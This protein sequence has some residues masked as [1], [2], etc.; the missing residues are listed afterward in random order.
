MRDQGRRP[1]SFTRKTV[2]ANSLQAPS[3]KRD[4][5]LPDPHGTAIPAGRRKTPFPAT[6]APHLFRTGTPPLRLN[7]PQRGRPRSSHI[8]RRRL[9]PQHPPYPC[10]MERA[11]RHL[12][13][14]RSRVPRSSR[15]SSLFPPRN[16]RTRASGAG[17]SDPVK[18]TPTSV[19]PCAMPSTGPR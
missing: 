19:P 1:P 16:P 11:P 17:C 3:K 2:P 5:P 15:D 6:Q 4:P 18:P 10:P 13:P 12:S 8:P 7:T 14:L 9:P